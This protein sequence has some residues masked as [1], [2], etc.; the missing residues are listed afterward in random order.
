MTAAPG[1]LVG[2]FLLEPGLVR[3]RMG[4]G[5][6]ITV[7]LMLVGVLDVIVVMGSVLVGVGLIAVSVLM[8]VGGV[9]N[10]V[11]GHGCSLWVLAGSPWRLVGAAGR[12]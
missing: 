10:M 1:S 7:V 6:A 2:V 4:V 3:V 5:L 8:A 11:C 12:R 9:V